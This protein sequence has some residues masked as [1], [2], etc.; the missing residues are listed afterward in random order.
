MSEVV[1]TSQR[2]PRD[3]LLALPAGTVQ[4]GDNFIL[5]FAGGRQY[6][7]QCFSK[8]K[9]EKG[10]GPPVKINKKTYPTN[11]LI[12]LPYGTVLEQ[13][14][15]KLVPLAPEEGLMPS[16]PSVAT[17]RVDPCTPATSSQNNS[18]TDNDVNESSL[19]TRDNRHLVDN[20]TSQAL[21]Q[22]E[23]KR[24]RESGTDGSAIV[25]MIIENSATFSQ[26]TDFSRAKYVARKQ[27]KYQ[28]RCRIV[29]CT[30]ATVCEALYLKDP[31]KMMNM[32]DDTLGQ[33]LSCSNVSAGCQ[34]LVMET[35]MGVVTGALAQRMGG[36]GKILSVYSGNQ[37]A[38]NEMIG[39]FNL[40]FG[41]NLSIKWVHSGDVFQGDAEVGENGQEEEDLEKADRDVLKWPCPLQEHTRRYLASM[42]SQR[43]RTKFL[44]RRSGR[45]AR[46]LTRHSPLE[47]KAMLTSRRSDS[48]IIVTRY[49]PTETLLEM[50]P[51]LAPSRS[52]MS[53]ARKSKRNECLAYPFKNLTTFFSCRTKPFRGVL[54]IY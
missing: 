31:R 48:L 22:Q 20:N 39:R 45:F 29:R 47:G 52:V 28:P 32:R 34:V 46:K 13:G 44:A 43:E 10:V 21:D 33:I 37:P 16:F 3:P 26:K 1:S 11:N 42:D 4:E 8:K 50:L 9:G 25:D 30:P 23:L 18:D 53:P 12:G 38:F 35:C 40:T 6:F 15:S 27:L 41:E 24:L 17:G 54:R 14:P 7:G 19:Y 2:K 36:Y 49:D 51:Y 5:V